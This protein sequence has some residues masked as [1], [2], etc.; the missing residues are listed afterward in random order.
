M[1]R[2]LIKKKGIAERTNYF[3]CFPPTPLPHPRQY[4]FNIFDGD[5]RILNERTMAQMFIALAHYR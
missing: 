2:L 4:W 5:I 3:M 1:V